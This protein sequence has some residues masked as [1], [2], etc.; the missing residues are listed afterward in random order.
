MSTNCWH[1]G[2]L[3]KKQITTL[4]RMNHHIHTYH[5]PN[6]ERLWKMTDRSR[7]QT[8]LNFR[9]P[10]SVIYKYNTT[11]PKYLY[12]HNEE[13]YSLNVKGEGLKSK[14]RSAVHS[15]ILLQRIHLTDWKP[16]FNH[17]PAL[18]IIWH[19]CSVTRRSVIRQASSDCVSMLLQK[20]LY[21]DI[22]SSWCNLLKQRWK[23]DMQT[24]SQFNHIL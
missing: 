13:L 11:F 17:E 7:Q 23:Y 2:L 15:F 14:Y 22:L 10:N 19:V 24:S 3:L 20:S 16:N 21:A 18:K 12:T 8:T 9:D 5:Q 4:S 6:I 1:R